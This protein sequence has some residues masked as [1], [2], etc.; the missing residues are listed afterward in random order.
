VSAGVG[1]RSVRPP[2]QRTAETRRSGAIRACVDRV[3]RPPDQG[4]AQTRHS[5]LVEGFA[6]RLVRLADQLPMGSGA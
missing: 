2:D 3:V 4:T 5:S 6:G 1:A